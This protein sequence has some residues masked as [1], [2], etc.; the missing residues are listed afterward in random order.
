MTDKQK[1]KSLNNIKADSAQPLSNSI[2]ETLELSDQQIHQA[3]T[4]LAQHSRLSIGLLHT[5][6][7][8]L[9][10]KNQKQDFFAARAEMLSHEIRFVSKE[11]ADVLLL[12]QQF[13]RIY[14]EFF[15]ADVVP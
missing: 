2:L 8:S 7:N 13:N 5:M 15:P 12:Y 3:L 6:L 11:N 14:P 10:K 1:P 9:V 4:F